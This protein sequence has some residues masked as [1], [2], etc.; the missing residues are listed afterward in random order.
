MMRI[1]RRVGWGMADQMAS[2]L[3]NFALGVFV[4]RQVTTEA[5]GA[6]ALAFVTYLFCL[7][8]GRAAVA[9]PMLIR[10]SNVDSSRWIDGARR[11]ALAGFAVGGVTGVACVGAGLLV[12][13]QLGAALVAIG[14]VMPALLVQDAWRY[15]FFSARRGRDAFVN[16][17]LRA[18]LLLPA[19]GFVVFAGD[20][21]AA[22]PILAWGVTAAIAGIVGFAQARTG[23]GVRGGRSWFVEHSD[24]I[25]RFAGESVAMVGSLQLSYF[26]IGAVGG[27]AVI[28]AIRAGELVLGPFNILSMGAVLI[29][30]PEATRLLARSVDALVRGCR[31]MSG[32]LTSAGVAFG[33]AATLLP[34]PIGTAIAGASWGPA[35]E[36]L[37][38]LTVSM[39][40]M[41][42][43]SGQRAGLRALEEANRILRIAVVTSFAILSGATIG[44]VLGGAVGAAWG[45]ALGNVVGAAASWW[46]FRT[47]IRRRRGLPSFGKPVTAGTEERLGSVDE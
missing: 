13:G 45:L 31:L 21:S 10:Y 8:L 7:N 43:G 23:I 29:A 36:V 30:V 40:A 35:Q 42:A 22:A 28:G 14:V 4:A 16:D 25:P 24:L 20:G 9:N 39:S 11:G 46:D 17:A 12:G 18:V 15:A 6:F 19:F 33:L 5:F 41:A 44:V 32:L 38:P 1:S 37:V 47:A 2:S 3:T 27:L 34:D 26:I